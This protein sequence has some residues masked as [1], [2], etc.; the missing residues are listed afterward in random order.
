VYF[1]YIVRYQPL[2]ILFFQNFILKKLIQ[3]TQ[4]QNQEFL[5]KLP[6]KISAVQQILIGK[7]L[8][9]MDLSGMRLRNQYYKFILKLNNRL[10]KN[11]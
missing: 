7:N 1:L 6:V 3:E 4:E 8:S 5:S 11:I 2:R 10:K 9:I